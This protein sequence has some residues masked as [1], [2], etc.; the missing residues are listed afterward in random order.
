MLQSNYDPENIS[1]K[2]IDIL[3][4]T[5]YYKSI[6]EIMGYTAWFYAPL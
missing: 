4:T 2:I 5:R 1:Q 6:N 3:L